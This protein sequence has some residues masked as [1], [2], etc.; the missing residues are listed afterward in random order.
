[1]CPGAAEVSAGAPGYGQELYFFVNG[2]V[3]P[4]L[5][6]TLSAAAFLGWGIGLLASKSKLAWTLHTL[7]LLSSI[8]E[9]N[10]NN[11]NNH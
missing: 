6:W 9:N 8:L 1:M 4:K 2:V 10:K 11:E 7:C 5:A 3:G